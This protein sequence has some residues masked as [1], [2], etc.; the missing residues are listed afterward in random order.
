M[1]VRGIVIVIIV[2]VAGVINVDENC[3]FCLLACSYA[4]CWLICK[5]TRSRRR[6]CNDHQH[7]LMQHIT[8]K[9]IQS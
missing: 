3:R 9:L 2:A 8:S 1:N 6:K 7:G 5:S 4:A